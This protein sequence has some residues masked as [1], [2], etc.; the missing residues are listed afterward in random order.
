MAK[1]R[2]GAASIVA[3]DASPLRRTFSALGGP[4]E[5]LVD[6][7]DAAE[8]DAVLEA[9]QKEAVRIERKFSRYRTDGV[10]HEINASGGRP[11]RVDEETTMLL[12]YAATCHEL[13]SGLFDITS[14][15]LR[16]AWTFDGTGNL[17]SEEDVRA[18]LRY[19]G[20]EKVEWS[21]PILVLPEG[22]EIDLGGIGKEYAVDRAAMLARDATEAPFV[23]NFGGDLFASAPRR[24]GLPW[25]IGIEDPERPSE[26]VLYRVD[27]MKGGL[28]T[29]GTARRFV[30]SGGR[31]LGHILDPRTG[32]PVEGA[33]SS[34][35]VLAPTCLEAGT[36]ATLAHLR[37]AEAKAFLEAEG[38]QFVAHG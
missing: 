32:R 23:V 28:A 14:G 13:S 1:S 35:T 31:R 27:L 18:A 19:V 17:P 21:A 24:G 20:W 30:R 11:I 36:L 16:R 38:V 3:H 26:S 2:R 22:M 5:V 12:D 15:A 6:T 8:A 34:I 29:S 37:G 4:C 7:D 10:V 9:A 33:P 25:V